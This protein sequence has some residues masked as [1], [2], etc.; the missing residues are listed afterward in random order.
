MVET[1][2]RR[3]IENAGGV[4][5]GGFIQPAAAPGTCFDGFEFSAASGKTDFGKAQENQAKDGAGVFLRFQAGVR[6]K[7]VGGV[8]EAFFQ[9]GDSS[10]FFGSGNPVQRGISCF[11]SND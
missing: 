10:I 7:L 4:I 8:P 1:R 9:S 11:A 6:A 2:F 5:C 3:K